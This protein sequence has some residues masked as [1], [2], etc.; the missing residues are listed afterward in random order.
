MV[1][2]LRSSIVGAEV[3][4]SIRFVPTH[5][6][7][8]PVIPISV[9]SDPAFIAADGGGPVVNV[10]S[11]ALD[12]VLDTGTLVKAGLTVIKLLL[13]ELVAPAGGSASLPVEID[14]LL[15]IVMVDGVALVNCK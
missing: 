12:H 13:P 2:V 5:G 14:I 10:K 4:L 15:V 9:P 11:C 3:V 6:Y 1:E 7:A 8:P